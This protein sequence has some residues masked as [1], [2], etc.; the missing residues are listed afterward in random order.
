[1]LEYYNKAY[2][3]YVSLFLILSILNFA[4]LILVFLKE[5]KGIVIFLS[6]MYFNIATFIIWENYAKKNVI[7]ITHPVIFYALLWSF[8]FGIIPLLSVFIS[9]SNILLSKSYIYVEYIP[10]SQIMALVS[11]LFMYMGF[12]FYQK[13]K[14][15]KNDK[16]LKSW[17]TFPFYT[18]LSLMVILTILEIVYLLQRDAFILGYTQELS[19]H[20]PSLIS[21]ILALFG[22]DRISIFYLGGAIILTLIF[23]SQKLNKKMKI[24]LFALLLSNIILSIVS[25]QKERIAIT[26]I[27]FL[28]YA[29]YWNK[30]R[31]NLN[32]EKKFIYFV[33]IFIITMPLFQAYRTA[34]N[35]TQEKNLLLILQ[36]V[37]DISFEGRDLEFYFYPLKRFDHLTTNLSVVAQTPTFIDYRLGQSYLKSLEAFTILIPKYP[38]TQDFG[39]FNNTFAREY[40]LVEPFDIYTGI[41]LPQFT[42]IYMNFGFYFIPIGMFLLGCFYGFIYNLIRKSNPNTRFIAFILYYIWVVSFSGLAFSTTMILTI[43]TLVSALIFLFLLN[44]D[45][46]LKKIIYK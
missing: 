41:T 20:R 45:K 8:P 32:F 9:S 19:E 22:Y 28:V 13:I 46:I 29:Y 39:K 1:M 26:L 12:K 42:E 27:A 24:I 4:M 15:F 17:G 3:K 10:L 14:P 36:N 16:S 40:N 6:F 18:T 37:I 44:I 11:L 21:Y 5:E 23:Y 30:H 2:G 34:I 31:F 38:K 25:A 7:E 35:L 43:K 33:I